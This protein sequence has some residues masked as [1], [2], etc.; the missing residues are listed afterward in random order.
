MDGRRFDDSIMVAFFF[1]RVS[2]G[3]S[4]LH[5]AIVKKKMYICKNSVRRVFLYLLVTYVLSIINDNIRL[6]LIVSYFVYKLCL[7]VT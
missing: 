6:L 1:L 3:Y 2:C 7:F 4:L 5:R